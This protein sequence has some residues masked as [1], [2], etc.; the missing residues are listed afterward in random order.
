[1]LL[2]LTAGPAVFADAPYSRPAG[3]ADN[4]EP[5]IAAG[6][7]A[8]FT[9]SAH[10]H[11]G[12]PLDDIIRVEL[13]DTRPLNL[14][15]PVIDPLRRLVLAS[16]GAGTT[17]IAAHR[18][19][20]GCTVLPA[21]WDASDVSRLPYVEYAPGADQSNA[22]FPDGD[23]IMLNGA[24][25]NGVGTRLNGVSARA[26]D[27]ASYGEGSLTTGLMVI[28]DGTP[29]LERYRPGFGPYSGYRTWSTA[30][31]I[32]AAVIGIAV[33]DGL[34]DPRAPVPIPEWSYP[35]DPR[36]AITM[37]HLF[38]MSSGLVSGGNNTSA[39]YFGGQDARSAI[40]S[41]ALEVEPGTR[42][43]YANNDTLL[44]LRALRGRLG[45]DLDYLRF[46]YDRLLRKIGM[47]HTRMEVDHDGN[48]IGSSQIYTTLRDL[49]RFGLLLANDGV[50]NGERLLPEGWVKFLTTAAPTRPRKAGERGYGAQ[51]WL[52]DTMPGVPMGTYTSAGNK[53]QCNRRTRAESGHRTDW[54]E[55]GRGRFCTGAVGGGYSRRARAVAVITSDS[56]PAAHPR[57]RGF[58][59]YCLLVLQKPGPDHVCT[60]NSAARRHPGRAHSHRC[61]VHREPSQP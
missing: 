59:L 6:F 50:W 21:H 51:V 49:V 29:I 16:D 45:D 44:L 61:G 34:L 9:C 25:I 38:W 53:G 19:T 42:W 3:A 10:F 60:G 4:D 22:L 7:R 11:A 56:G 28:L 40:T 35:G 18:D 8:L 15:D 46:P 36:R 14:P 24:G 43:K 48:F 31:T 47:Y 17:R 55:P 37:E 33:G 27:G 30:K 32:T 52:L 5:Y 1:M 58:G 12:R 26:F 2:L 41:T 20:M 54:R 13:A 23:R 57:A 39:V